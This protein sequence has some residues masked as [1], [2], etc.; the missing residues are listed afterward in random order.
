VTDD[1]LDRERIRAGAPSLQVRLTWEQTAR[2]VAMLR[3]TI[4]RFG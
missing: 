2:L 4:K 3:H 1:E